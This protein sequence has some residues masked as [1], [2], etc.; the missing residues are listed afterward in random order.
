[1]E[2]ASHISRN[3]HNSSKVMTGGVVQT[4]HVS[5]HVILPLEP[6]LTEGTLKGL[7][8]GVGHD[9]PLEVPHEFDVLRAVGA[10]VTFAPLRAGE[11]G[12]TGPLNCSSHQLRKEMGALR[13]F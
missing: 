5:L 3:G 12:A 10:H 11:Y 1:M 13:V 4:H 9:M 6:Q 2:H 7:L 8:I